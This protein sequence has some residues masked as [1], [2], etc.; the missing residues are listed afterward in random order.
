MEGQLNPEHE[1]MFRPEGSDFYNPKIFGELIKARRSVRKF[2]GAPIPRNISDEVLEWG[3]LAPNSSN[4]QTWE[5][6]RVVDP[7]MIASLSI[8]C[9]SQSAARTSSE[10]IVAIARTD[11]ALEHCDLMLEEFKKIEK[12][13]GEPTPK[14]ALQYYKTLAPMV[15]NVGPFSLYAPFKWLMYT[16]MGWFKVVPREPLTLGDVKLWSVKSCALACENIM[17]GFRAHGYDTCPMEGF[18]G[19]RVKKILN[20]SRHQHVVM[21]IGAGKAVPGGVYGPQL[22]FAKEKFIKTI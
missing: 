4:L 1:K 10:L 22:R 14:V 6:I 20:L 21:I 13:T 16:V 15:Y 5:F 11:K 2:D 8:A 12:M 9:F 19:S 7:K 18:D 17:L 3:L